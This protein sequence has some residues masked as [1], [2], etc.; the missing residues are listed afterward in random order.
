MDFTKDKS[1][2]GRVQ[3][4]VGCSSQLNNWIGTGRDVDP[5]IAA[6]CFR[7]VVELR[8][9]W[10]ANFA[11]SVEVLGRWRMLTVQPR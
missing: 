2:M 11:I 4:S 6:N 3:S 9:S 8:E 10:S 5:E 1:L 7:P